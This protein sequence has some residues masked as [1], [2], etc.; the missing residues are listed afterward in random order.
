[1]KVLNKKDIKPPTLPKETVDV[2]ELGGAVVVRG[3]LL[4]ERVEL[5]A[6]QEDKG[7]THISKMLS[8]TV[9]DDKG[10]PVFT[11]DE[12]E[13]FGNQHFSASLHLLEVAKRLSGMNVEVA[14]KK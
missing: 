4:R 13:E 1:M 5:L 2:P 8:L 6:S 11:Q 9:V 12:W 10:A 14:Q 3:L 7:Y